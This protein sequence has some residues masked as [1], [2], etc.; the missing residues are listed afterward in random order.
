MITVNTPGG[1]SVTIPV[2]VQVGD[3]VFRQVNPISFTMPAS[4]ASPLPQF[5]TIASTGTDFA[6]DSATSNGN[7]GTWLQVTSC[8]SYCT[9]PEVITLTPKP[10]AS[11]A[12]G[13]YT[14]E[15]TFTAHGTRALVM[16]VPVTLTVAQSSTAFFD[17]LP[18][19]VSFSMVP[20]TSN[21]PL[22][23][24]QIRNEGS[25]TLSWTGSTSTADGGKWLTL[26]ALSGTAPSTVSVS[27][28][29][30]NLPGGGLVAGT[31]IGSLSFQA[32]GNSITIPVSVII[33]NSVFVQV[34]ALQFSRL[35]GAPN[36]SPQ[37]FSVSSTG[38]NFAFDSVTLTGNG[39]SWLKSTSC[40]SYCTTPQ[41]IT[42]TIIA[43]ASLAVGTYTGEIT[44]TS[45]GTRAMG[46]TVPVTLT[47]N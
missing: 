46:M 27:V 31:Y 30:Q 41:A 34:Q 37:T 22:Q 47:I 20:G 39:G 25:G 3:N 45:H 42:A 11:L 5:I 9:T 7:G 4:G 40:G 10:S 33:G 8:G 29:T 14:A 24:M 43:P 44:F 18:G 19:Q 21:P 1:G 12:A 15:V 35:F 36:P 2:S 38:T 32:T 13:I 28:K 17:N 26:S 16:T 6:F 23:S